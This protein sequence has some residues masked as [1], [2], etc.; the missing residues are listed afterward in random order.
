MPRRDAAPLTTGKCWL[1]DV[2]SVHG[3]LGSAGAYDGMKSQ[4]TCKVKCLL[5]NLKATLTS[6][7][8]TRTKRILTVTRKAHRAQAKDM[9]NRICQVFGHEVS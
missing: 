6:S 2:A 8:I 5:H 4:V 1:Q 3:S 7:L 9:L